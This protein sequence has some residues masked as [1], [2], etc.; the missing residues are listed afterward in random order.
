MQEIFGR[1]FELGIKP[2]N[3]YDIVYKYRTLEQAA[4]IIETKKY[5]MQQVSSFGI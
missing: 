5:G 2:Y 3:L 1:M 4:E